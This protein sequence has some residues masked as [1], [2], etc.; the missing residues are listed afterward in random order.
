M[1]DV[2]YHNCYLEVR[3][4]VRSRLA[5]SRMQLAY[6][7][8]QE[9]AQELR[10]IM[11]ELREQRPEEATQIFNNEPKHDSPTFLPES[12]LAHDVLD[13]LC[14]LEIGAAAHNAFGLNTKNVGISSEM[15]PHDFEVY[16]QHQIAFCGTY[17]SID[18]P[19]YADAIPVAD[20]SQDFIIHSHV[21][22][23]LPNP[24]GGLA[25]WVRVVK[26]GGYIYAIVPK[27]D[28]ADAGRDV[29][30]LQ[31]TILHYLLDSPA[32]ARALLENGV[33]RGH[34]TVFDGDSLTDIEDWFNLYHD[35]AQLSRVAY[36]ETDDKAGNG[37]AIVWQVLKREP[38]RDS[39]T[40]NASRHTDHHVPDADRHLAALEKGAPSSAEPDH[41]SLPAAQAYVYSP[42]ESGET[43]RRAN[44]ALVAHKQEVLVAKRQI[45]DLEQKLRATERQLA[46]ARLAR[47][48]EESR[49]S[50]QAL[51]R[52]QLLATRVI[53]PGSARSLLLRRLTRPV[54]ATLSI[55]A[56]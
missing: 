54:K 30:P 18:I 27:R 21:W 12:A 52:F 28:A 25:E 48:N 14:G 23:H 26:P 6:A 11:T 9:E 22:E 38:A 29:T 5:T 31:T 15:E 41:L 51:M 34:Y 56:K 35:D 47:Q 20:S 32:D 1:S 2:T 55:R 53:P 36:Q 17:A 49:L 40:A 13:G 10:D 24:L 50:Y 39:V 37:H 43:A 42:T 16:K 44:D 3:S 19:G 7:A 8:A 46:E 45:R 33:S 4:R